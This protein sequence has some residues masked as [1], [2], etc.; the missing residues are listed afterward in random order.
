MPVKCGIKPAKNGGFDIS[1]KTRNGE[2]F[3]TKVTCNAKTGAKNG[4]E[5]VKTNSSSMKT[6]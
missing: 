5:P 3:I 6:M 1:L 4:I 2:I